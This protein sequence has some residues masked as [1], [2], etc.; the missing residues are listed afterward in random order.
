MRASV[1]GAGA[2]GTALSDLLARAGHDVTLWARE[3]D[4][5]EHVNTAHA[6]PR[7]LAG[8]T[9]HPGVRATDDPVECVRDV[10]L[11]VY[12]APSHVLRTVVRTSA[13]A[14]S[15]GAILVIA[16][17]GIEPESLLL[18]SDV[19]SAELPGRP[20][21]ALSG[22]SFAIEVARRQPTAV[23]AAS[24][25][26]D[27]ST[28]VQQALSTSHFRVYTS[29]DMRGVELAGALKNVMAVAT[30]IAEGLGLGL[31]SRAALITRGLAE[32]TRL[33]VA[34]GAQAATFAGLAGLGDLVL[35]CTGALSRNRAV[36]V[37]VGQGRA[38]DEILAGTETVAEGVRNARSTVALASLAGVAMPIAEAVHRVLFESQLPREAIA[39]LMQRELRAERDE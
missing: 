16:T 14:V 12:A 24:D 10:A 8:V 6:N 39:G 17:K 1:M 31:N 26:A 36:G 25:D 5:V 35:T 23:V 13:A 19:V 4:V 37:E 9:L 20:V 28:V 15:Q 33:G 11:V 3:P 27:A 38:L 2:W 29:D 21:V 30:G 18:L 32:T 34:L 7:F 22:P